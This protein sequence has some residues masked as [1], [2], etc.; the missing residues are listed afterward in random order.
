MVGENG[1][2]SLVMLRVHLRFFAHAQNEKYEPRMSGAGQ[3]DSSLTLRMTLL[4]DPSLFGS[5]ITYSAVFA[6]SE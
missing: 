3:R 1:E 6:C 5:P 2:H 4:A